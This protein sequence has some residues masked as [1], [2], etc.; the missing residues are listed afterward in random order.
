MRASTTLLRRALTLT[1]S[2]PASCLRPRQRAR[3]RAELDAPRVNV[4]GWGEALVNPTLR[5]TVVRV[6]RIYREAVTELVRRAQA[7]G[8][9]DGAVDPAAQANALLAL[10]YGLELQLA[11]EPGLDVE[12]YLAAAKGMLS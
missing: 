7:A 2:A 6:L 4:Q 5:E 11:L 3:I 8:Q 10:Y 1:T 12:G 9:I